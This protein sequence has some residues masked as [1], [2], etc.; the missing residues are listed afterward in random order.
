MKGMARVVYQVSGE[1]CDINPVRRTPYG[2][3]TNG[4]CGG[5]PAVPPVPDE[6]VRDS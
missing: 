6:P 5:L 2:V 4:A 1:G 3:T